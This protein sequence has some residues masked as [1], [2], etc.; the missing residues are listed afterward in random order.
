MLVEAL[1]RRLNDH[2][3]SFQLMGEDLAL[4]DGADLQAAGEE[5]RRGLERLPVELRPRVVAEQQRLQREAHAMLRQHNRS[6]HARIAGYVAIGRRCDFAYPWPVVAILGIEQ[7]LTGMRHNR[8]YGLV[9]ELAA[10]V[11]WKQ[12]GA[13][14]DGSEDVLRRTNRGIFADSIPTVLY[15]L[16][17]VELARAGDRA[18]ADALVD[19]P[20][21]PLM[22][23]ECRALARALVHGLLLP[24]GES[25]FVTLAELTM[26]HF[27]REQAIFTF[28]MG[29]SESQP[30]TAPP[31]SPLLRR[32]TA[33]RSVP[34]PVVV[35]ARGRRR[36]ELREVPLPRGFDMR[37]HAARVDAFG[38]AFVRSVTGDRDDYRAAV[39]HVLA[40]WG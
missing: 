1:R 27:A 17:V 18:L 37:D 9:G 23:E 3:H 32:L 28:H 19:G 14:S 36:V 21:P 11:G 33:L 12:L 15:A 35:R 6:V 24:E 34:A 7:V 13:I 5:W 20:L 31:R 25:R 16:G 40:R 4:V 29:A 10:R 38:R 30:P 8:L 22:D 2:A 39:A 26:R